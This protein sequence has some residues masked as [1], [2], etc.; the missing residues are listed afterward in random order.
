MKIDTAEMKQDEFNTIL[1]ALNDYSPKAQKYIEAK[2]G[3]LNNA[4]NFYK[5]REKIIKDFKDGIFS[6]KS[7]INLKN[8]KLVQK[9]LLINQQ[10]LILMN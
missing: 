2:N 7:E 1:D 6:L 8:N 10:E 3:L 9:N 5:G 4:K